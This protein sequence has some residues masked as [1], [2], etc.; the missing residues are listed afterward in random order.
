MS[1][2]TDG[3]EYQYGPQEGTIEIFMNEKWWGFATE[4]V[5]QEIQFPSDTTE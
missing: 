4:E 1:F 5:R 3:Y 2:D